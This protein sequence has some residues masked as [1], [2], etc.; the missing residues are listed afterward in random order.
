MNQ[1]IVTAADAAALEAG[2][3]ITVACKLQSWLIWGKK[4]TDMTPHVLFWA[5]YAVFTV[6]PLVAYAW[7]WWGGVFS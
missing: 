5:L 6:P 7:H 3:R 1:S 2:E 4:E